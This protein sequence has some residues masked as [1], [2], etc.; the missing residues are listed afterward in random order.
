MLWRINFINFKI[1]PKNI[2]KKQFF[3]KLES[4]LYVILLWVKSFL[5]KMGNDYLLSYL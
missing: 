1:T 4:T 3:K 5:K 2:A